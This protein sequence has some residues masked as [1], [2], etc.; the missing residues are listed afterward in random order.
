VR[1]EQL[2]RAQSAVE[3]VFRQGTTGYDLQKNVKDY[4]I[5]IPRDAEV[6]YSPDKKLRQKQGSM[7][8]KVTSFIAVTSAHSHNSLNNR[9]RISNKKINKGRGGGGG[10]IG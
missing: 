2:R 1:E 6:I 3:N 10:G 7:S 9:S 5:I 8:S 4:Q